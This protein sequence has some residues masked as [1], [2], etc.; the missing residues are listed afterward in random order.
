MWKD[1]CAG[2]AAV[3]TFQRLLAVAGAALAI[4]VI[5]IISFMR[6]NA[7]SRSCGRSATSPDKRAVE[8][9]ALRGG[10]E[11][12]SGILSTTWSENFQNDG[13]LADI[14]NVRFRLLVAGTRSVCFPGIQSLSLVAQ[15]LDRVIPQLVTLSQRLLRTGQGRERLL[16]LHGQLHPSLVLAHLFFEG[17]GDAA[18]RPIT[19][20]RTGRAAAAA[21][22]AADGRHWAGAVAFENTKLATQK[23]LTTFVGLLSFFEDTF[24]L[25][26]HL[27]RNE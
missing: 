26:G 23:T 15:L 6:K 7:H 20:C 12:N 10:G 13:D 1:L 9:P 16:Q 21:G 3:A 22:F 2:S 8:R 11:R 25:R 27:R 17:T 5:M 19:G 4:I 14:L 24:Q 18:R